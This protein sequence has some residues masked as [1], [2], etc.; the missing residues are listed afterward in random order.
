MLYWRDR[1]ARNASESWRRDTTN[2]HDNRHNNR[3]NGLE[4]VDIASSVALAVCVPYR[5][6]NK[7]ASHRGA[8][9]NN[10]RSSAPIW[11]CL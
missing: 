3:H 2:R 11:L 5:L 4:N 7:A 6:V 1:L 9:S 8:R 10:G